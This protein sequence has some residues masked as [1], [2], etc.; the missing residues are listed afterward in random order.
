MD[1]QTAREY[2]EAHGKAVFEGDTEHVK[3]DLISELHPMLDQLGEIVPSPLTDVRVVS[4]DAF[5]DH[6]ESVIAYSGPDR[7]LKMKARWED[8]DGRPQIVAAEPV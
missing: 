7:T 6:A 2:S 1:E 5:D 4:V 3:A 8:R